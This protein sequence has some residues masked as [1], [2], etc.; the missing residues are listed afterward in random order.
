MH[1]N[2]TLTSR[3]CKATRVADNSSTTYRPRPSSLDPT[4]ARRQV[5]LPSNPSDDDAG[6]APL[7]YRGGESSTYGKLRGVQGGVLVALA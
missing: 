4:L 5:L 2:R 6:G 7:L 3:T 1:M